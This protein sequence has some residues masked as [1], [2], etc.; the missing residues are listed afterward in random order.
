MLK[1][2][3]QNKEK[4]EKKKGGSY[5]IE[6]KASIYLSDL[7]EELDSQIDK[8]LVRT[9]KSLFM[10]L[11]LFRNSKLSLLLSELGGYL[12]GFAHAAAGTKRISNLL[13]SK[14]WSSQV[15]DDFF[16]SRSVCRS[17]ALKSAGK[18]PLFIWDDSRIEKPESWFSEGLCSVLS[19]K[20]KRLT[21]IKRGYYRPPTQRI[22]VPGFKWTGVLLSALGGIPSVCQ[23]SWWTTRGKHK[24]LGSNIMY[25]LLQKITQH[26][27][28]LGLHVLDRG[29]AN[30]TIIE[31]MLYHFKQDFLVR[32]K[33][34]HLL[35]HAEK[36]T[37][38]THLLARSFKARGR[39]VVWD[40][41]RRQHKSISI[42]WAAVKH[43]A[44]GDKQ[45]YLIIVRDRHNHISPMYLLTSVPIEN[46]KIAWEMFHSYMHRWNVEQAFRFCK[47]ELGMESPRLW[48]WENRLKLLGI[49]ALVYDFLLS[50]LRNWRTW[51]NIL[52]R[53]WCHR[54]GSRY[55][56]ATIP[57]Y[58]L[59]AAIA[60]CMLIAF[61]KSYP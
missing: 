53:N 32:W 6:K 46:A 1:N 36:G 38:K 42:A 57:I 30:E 24:D 13:R 31:W 50:L 54:T 61:A 3:S 4:K 59:R 2:T 27:G 51:T 33:K 20:G 26:I 14:K 29:Y 52:M 47:T 11:L 8:R 49:A 18:R 35:V 9:F 28:T 19:S 55:L 5:F 41:E 15:I 45:L 43:P 23:M 7:V 60:N 10:I 12:C 48:F 44:F 56:E 17:K 58:R 34:N 22:G 40:K 37:K 21:K 39:K 16:F 25:R